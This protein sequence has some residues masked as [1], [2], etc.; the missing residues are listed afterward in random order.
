LPE[1]QNPELDE[2][3]ELASELAAARRLAGRGRAGATQRAYRADLQALRAY[4]RRRGQGDELPVPAELVAAFIVS[5]SRPDRELR[6]GAR[7]ISTV[8]RRL[9]AISAAHRDAGL[10][11]PCTD[12]FVHETLRGIRRAHGTAREPKRNLALEDLDHMLA[13]IPTTTHAGRRDRAL[14]L[15]GLA[16]ALRRS[17]LVAIDCAHIRREAEGMILTIPH[18]KGDQLGAG[19]QISIAIGDR[20]DLCAVRAVEAWRTAAGIRI[21]PLFVRVRKGDQL[22]TERLSDRAVALIVKA[23]AA[24]VHLDPSLLAGH[25][26]RS[27]GITEARRNGHDEQEIAK[28]SR[29]RNMDIL[30]GYIRAADSFE[31]RAQVLQSR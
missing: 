10:P 18:S 7:A 6:R 20:A 3:A 5:E 17:E 24:P 19:Q 8:E 31:G 30:R 2:N 25:S 16:G 14:L 12:P 1:D 27:G 9:A 11:D 15:L 23:R 4:L 28:L 22:T 26:L 13:A 29:H 21:G